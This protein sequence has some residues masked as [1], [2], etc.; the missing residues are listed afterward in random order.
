M[1]RPGYA[2]GAGPGSS[3]SEPSYPRYQAPDDSSLQL[4]PNRR[5]LFIGLGL[6]V[7]GLIVLLAITL[8]GGT[9]ENTDKQPAVVMDPRAEEP[10]ATTAD[11][12]PK[13]EPKQPVVEAKKPKETKEPKETKAVKVD[14]KKPETADL[15]DEKNPD[16]IDKSDEKP[17]ETT[18]KTD[19]KNTAN[20]APTE[21]VDTSIALDISSEPSGADVMLAGKVI[22]MTPLKTKVPKGT[23]LTTIIV[24]KAKYAD[25][26]KDID[27]SSDFK[28]EFVLKKLVEETAVKEPKKTPKATKQTVVKTQEKKTPPPVEKKT[29]PPVEK[30]P[31]CQPPGQLDPFDSRPPCK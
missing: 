14:E 24:H 1:T 22:G 18:D 30:K 5:P 27:L 26:S 28:T 7:L 19:E 6:A 8:G 17:P 31:A 15:K 21:P 12:P 4:T 9:D 16:K 10:T 11:N 13:E 20:V 25:A 23:S 2:S 3:I 29:P